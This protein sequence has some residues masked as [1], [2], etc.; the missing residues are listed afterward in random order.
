MSDLK[1]VLKYVK[2]KPIVEDLTDM[3]YGTAI[4]SHVNGKNTKGDPHPG[5]TEAEKSHLK[6]AFK[7]VADMLNEEADK[8]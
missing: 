6:P 5:L 8:M 4:T 3:T 1:K 7:K 2:L